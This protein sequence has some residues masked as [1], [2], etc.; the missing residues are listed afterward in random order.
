MFDK[1]DPEQNKYLYIIFTYN[2][3]IDLWTIKNNRVD[4]IDNNNNNNDNH[5]K[6]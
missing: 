3:I 1:T 6:K 4:T 5:T 2:N